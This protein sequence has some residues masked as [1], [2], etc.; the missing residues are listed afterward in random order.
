MYIV[1]IDLFYRH[2]CEQY[3][4]CLLWATKYCQRANKTVAYSDAYA[5]SDADPIADADPD[6]RPNTYIPASRLT[7]GHTGY[8]CRPHS[9]IFR[10]SLGAAGLCYLHR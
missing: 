3:L 4:A 9:P 8:R 1:Q 5:H 6:A 7:F 2:T 10:F